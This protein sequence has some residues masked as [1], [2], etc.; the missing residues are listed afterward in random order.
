MSDEQVPVG[1]KLKFVRDTKIPPSRYARGFLRSE[2][3]HG[4][5]MCADSLSML[6]QVGFRRAK[7]W[8]FMSAVGR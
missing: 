6:W 3:E 1:E 4:R 5:K 2:G 8:K 7:T